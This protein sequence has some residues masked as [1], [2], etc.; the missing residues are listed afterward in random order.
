M[1]DLGSHGYTPLKS[2]PA[3]TPIIFVS[4]ALLYAFTVSSTPSDTAKAQTEGICGR[5][6]GVR[7]AI[8]NELG[9]SSAD[10]GDVTDS[11]L[12][13]IK[14]L[15][16]LSF[17]GIA[18]GDLDGLASLEELTLRGYRF[19]PFPGGLFADLTSLDSLIVLDY[20]GYRQPDGLTIPTSA[21]Q[22][23]PET[24]E[25][26]VLYGPGISG[27]ETNA[28][29][30]LDDLKWLWVYAHQIETLESG[31]FN[32][33]GNLR[34]LVFYGNEVT[35]I[36]P[37][38]FSGVGEDVEDD[39]RAAADFGLLYLG[40]DALQ[41]LD[42]DTF[43]G[44]GNLE[45][46]AI[47]GDSIATIDS[48]AFN[49]LASVEIFYLSAGAI[50]TLD[51]GTFAPL[52]MLRLLRLNKGG[53]EILETDVPGEL[54]TV[55]ILDIWDQS[56][57]TLKRTYFDSLTGLERL[58]VNYRTV[59]E[60]IESN[61]FADLT[62]LKLLNIA[63]N[64]IE[65]LP[66][67]VFEPLASLEHLDLSNNRV[68]ALPGGFI[69]SPPCSLQSLNIGG[70][71]FRNVPTAEVD[72]IRR[73][74]LSTLPQPNKNGCGPDEGIRHIHLD[75]IPITQAEL[76]L[77][78]PYSVVETLSLA[79]TG[80]TATQAIDVRR[81]QDLVQ[82]KKLDLSYNDLS[83]LNDFQQRAALPVIVGR[84]NQL[85]EMLL[86]GT[87]I[88]GDT[89]MIIVQNLSPG[90]KRLSL[91]DNDLT[92]WNDPHL[93]PAL[94]SAFSG[95]NELWD[96]IDLSNTGL[97]AAAAD[98]I[99]PSIARKETGNPAGFYEIDEV[100]PEVTLNLS[101]NRLTRFEP[102]WIREW[103]QVNTIDI[104]CNEIE[105]TLDPGWFSRLAIHLQNLYVNGN[106]PEIID[107]AD[108]FRR[109]LPNLRARGLDNGE[110]CQRS[111]YSIPKSTSLILNIEPGIEKV[112]IGPG[113]VL[114]LEI[115]LYGRQN[116][117]DNDLADQV[118]IVWDDGRAGGTF[119]GAG[120]RIHYTAPENPGTYTV[121]VRVPASQCF[122]DFDQCSAEFQITVKRRSSVGTT[123]IE[124]ID[125]PGDIPAILTDAE[126][127][128]Y[129]VLT[130]VDGGRYIGDGFTLSAPP[131]AV[132]NGEFIGVS[133][134]K[135]EPA[136][137]IG[138]THHRYTI[139]GHWYEISTVDANRESISDYKLNVPVQ[140]CIPLPSELLSR[141]DGLAIVAR[142]T[143]ADS[144]T[145]ISSNVR[146]ESDGA[147]NL[148]GSLS[149]LPVEVAASK[150]GAPGALPT[151]T[152]AYQ[153]EEVKP[154][155]AGGS[156]IPIAAL[157]IAMIS[158]MV[159]ALVCARH[160]TRKAL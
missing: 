93:A 36:A 81:A 3:A 39:N 60:Q 58:R 18:S 79:N 136:S 19:F 132:E 68:S 70:N 44:L 152:P 12:A 64:L 27:F 91:A 8:L 131:G 72:G 143:D 89:A 28:F 134:Q 47:D 46:L 33:L 103:E 32:G 78:E 53:K 115:D 106:A 127:T 108:G 41:T 35:T 157:I 147:T 94:T 17:T 7:L 149:E 111:D 74:L 71:R 141:I 138:Q 48:G 45:R 96:L 126:G 97:D 139:E 83:G 116:V 24:V 14:H 112:V 50:N 77:I 56:I 145:V 160:L 9:L 20:T 104:S 158:G 87:K 65:T 13:I 54:T 11:R 135:G 66:E 129:E 5:S 121:L 61:A 123:P 107:D 100:D 86:A 88:D 43:T 42:R 148:C 117:L 26:L 130:P 154:P 122:G 34:W 144:F 137:N 84:L 69:A 29:S 2:I 98:S 90:A 6:L 31:I 146:I 25:E 82:I 75:N 15:S 49:D 30:G 23:L 59:V 73:N 67:R 102:S 76:D 4:V 1:S 85:E 55:K 155:D 119:S 125:P 40:L 10:C 113:E 109:A 101:N 110:N 80:I 124:P 63:N 151:P 38:A 37:G 159:A 156:E 22:E 16:I 150:R 153:P 140:V 133:V 51:P 120:R 128:A 114:R 21:F 99:I 62:R 95:L 52:S 118:L 142:N 105:A 57:T 92:D